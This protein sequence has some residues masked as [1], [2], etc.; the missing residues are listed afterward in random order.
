M[1]NDVAKASKG[2]TGTVDVNK[3]FDD[4]KQK[5]LKHYE[6]ANIKNLASQLDTSISDIKKYNNVLD[7]STFLELFSKLK[8][9]IK[10]GK[11][12]TSCIVNPRGRKLNDIQLKDVK[13]GTIKIRG[14]EEHI[15]LQYQG[16]TQ[17]WW[18]RKA[19]GLNYPMH[20]EFFHTDNKFCL[21]LKFD[22]TKK[23]WRTSAIKSFKKIKYIQPNEQKEVTN[24]LYDDDHL[25]RSM[26]AIETI[27]KYMDSYECENASEAANA[28]VG[29][30]IN[31]NEQ[32]LRKK[33]KELT[34]VD[35]YALFDIKAWGDEDRKMLERDLKAFLEPIGIELDEEVFDD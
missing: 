26:Q 31:D 2:K 30:I 11:D 28:A 5:A 3:I 29:K 10:N 6:N 4:I 24:V 14:P 8:S 25:K 27:S 16:Y 35:F 32:R 13:K 19:Y 15:M 1:I 9:K 21:D 33:K 34:A 18:I 23:V 7:L 20:G 22:E 17:D 12:Y